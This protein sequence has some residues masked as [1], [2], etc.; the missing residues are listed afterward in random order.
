MKIHNLKNQTIEEKKLLKLHGYLKK[1][2]FK[3]VI[4]DA[5][6]F[7][8]E[9]PDQPF[10]HTIISVAYLY[11]GDVKSALDILRAAEKKFPDDYQILFH[12]AK[13]YEEIPDFGKAVS[14][15]TRSFDATPEEYRDARSDCLNDIG[16]IQYRLGFKEEAANSWKKALATDPANYK[17]K[18]NLNM[19]R[20]K[21][22][23][24]STDFLMNE[25]MEFKSIQ[26]EKYFE[27]TGKEKF[28][29]KKEEKHFNKMTEAFWIN[30]VMANPDRLENSDEE[31][32]SRWYEGI[33]IDFSEPVPG[34]EVFVRGGEKEKLIN[35]KFPFLPEN[36]IKTSL[37]AGPAMDYTGLNIEK[38]QSFIK[39]EKPTQKEIEKLKWSYSLGEI[40]LKLGN[41]ESVKKQDELLNKFIE[42]LQFQLS[43][44]DTRIVLDK[45]ISSATKF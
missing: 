40:L 17:A 26:M 37:L 16:V 36:G 12:L 15:F 20:G 38:I 22:V 45:I 23:N 7:I 18:D 21:E 19:I 33:E 4:T 44:A 6:K 2:D 32:L 24:D 42:T 1:G 10:F 8:K 14:Y 11:T 39:G 35:D 43:E 41:T 34:T 13:V 25:F 9:H 29:T 27:K 5:G 28:S 31:E 3:K 30:E